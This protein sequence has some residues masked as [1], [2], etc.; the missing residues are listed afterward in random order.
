MQ[1]LL[2]ATGYRLEPSEVAMLLD[3]V[4]VGS[5][6]S[7][8]QAQFIASQVGAAAVLLKFRLKTIIEMVNYGNLTHCQRFLVEDH[9]DTT[10]A[11]QFIQSASE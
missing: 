10:S 6:D 2:P 3:K 5:R 4:A 9:W 7:L 1:S 8:S 11:V